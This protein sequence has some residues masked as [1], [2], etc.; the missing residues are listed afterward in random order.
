[1]PLELELQGLVNRYR[2][3]HGRWPVLPGG[4]LDEVVASLRRHLEESERPEPP[5]R[6]GAALRAA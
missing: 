6:G 1:M 3:L 2:R 5:F 4:S